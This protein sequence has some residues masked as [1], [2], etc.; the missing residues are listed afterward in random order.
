MFFAMFSLK[1]P[2]KCLL[3]FRN[4]RSTTQSPMFIYWTEQE[5]LLNRYSHYEQMD[6]LV[7]GD[8][9][10]LH[11]VPTIS[12]HFL[13]SCLPGARP[14]CTLLNSWCS[15]KLGFDLSWW[16]LPVSV[17]LLYS[18]A[19]YK[20]KLTWGQFLKRNNILLSQTWMFLSI[21]STAFLFHCLTEEY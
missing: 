2:V 4:I 18:K 17:H 8:Q 1:I 10:S 7:T 6:T 11:K 21:C 12:T 5:Q 13:L 19:S 16:P 14:L 15:W 9:E 20:S 3:D